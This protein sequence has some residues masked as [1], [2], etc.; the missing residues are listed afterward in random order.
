M[1]HTDA[2]G[3]W[4]LGRSLAVCLIALPAVWIGA[5]LIDYN[6]IIM[7]F[8]CATTRPDLQQKICIYI[9][10]VKQKLHY[11]CVECIISIEAARRAIVV[12]TLTNGRGAALV[13]CVLCVLGSKC[14]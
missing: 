12:H 2:A 3:G 14:R 13:G 7:A 5:E 4:A 9:A 1:N 11:I 6:A 8:M 10:M